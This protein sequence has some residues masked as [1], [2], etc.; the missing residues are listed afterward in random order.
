MD[1]PGLKIGTHD[2]KL[3]IR[4][5]PS[6]QVFLT[7][8]ARAGDD[9]LLGAEGE[10]FKI[11]MRALDG[12]RIG[13]AAQALGIARAAFEDATRYALE[14]KTFGQ[15]IAEH[16]AIQFKLAD[17]RTEIDAARLLLW[18][19]AVEEGPRR[20]LRHARP[21]MAKLF[22]LRGRQP[23]RQGSA[24]DLRRLRLPDR[25]SRPSGTTATPRSPRSTKEPARS[26]AWSSLRPCSRSEPG[27][28]FAAS[29][30]RRD[31]PWAR[32]RKMIR[33]L[34]AAQLA[35]LALLFAV[36][37]PAAP[38]RPAR[39]GRRQRRQEPRRSSSPTSGIPPDKEAEVQL[40]LQQRNPSTLKCY[41]DVLNEKHDRAFKG[42][43]IVLLSLEPSGSQSKAADVKVIGGTMTDKEV[44]SC[45]IEKLKEFDYPEIPPP[46]RCSTSTAS[47][48]RID[49]SGPARKPEGSGLAALEAGRPRHVAAWSRDKLRNVTRWLVAQHLR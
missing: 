38:R 30:P 24:A 31:A 43:V 37:P 2:D 10:G 36:S 5:A 42:T 13:I 46:A 28:K 14:R 7:D 44:T 49:P 18:R 40:L 3:G 19:A 21:S 29:R 27:A 32:S 1:A 47:N 25:L 41:S 17:M 35:A 23:R 9:A 26:S 8:C 48:P 6:A 33:R 34:L 45:V 11:A 12:G 15:P 16:Q 39:R 20:A 22:A 4:G